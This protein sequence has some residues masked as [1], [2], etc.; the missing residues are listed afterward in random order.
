[1]ARSGTPD[2]RQPARRPRVTLFFLAWRSGRG[3]LLAAA[4]SPPNGLL[5][6]EPARRRAGVDQIAA[7]LGGLEGPPSDRDLVWAAVATGRES[8]LARTPLARRGWRRRSLSSSSRITSLDS[9]A[10]RRKAT[11][12]VFY[13]VPNLAARP[14][15]VSDRAARRRASPGRGAATRAG[16]SSSLGGPDDTRPD[17]LGSKRATTSSRP[18]PRLRCWSPRGG[19]V[20]ASAPRSATWWLFGVV[21]LFA[22][23]G[24]GSSCSPSNRTSS[25]AMVETGSHHPMTLARELLHPPT[26]A[27]SWGA[28]LLVLLGWA[29]WPRG[30]LG[31]RCRP[32]WPP[33]PARLT[34]P[35]SS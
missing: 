35:P 30:G 16:S 24:L 29:S 8:A 4:P 27:A 20:R 26:G 9:W 21:L 25:W 34:S 32:P 6:E 14:L 1:M 33:Q 10:L 7:F 13:Y 11:S 28:L 22:C 12:F 2:T 5:V 23:P 15:L 31:S 3:S 17:G 19:F 18:T